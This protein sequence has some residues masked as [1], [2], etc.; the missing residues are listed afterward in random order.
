MKYISVASAVLLFASSVPT[1]AASSPSIFQKGRA[2]SGTCFAKFRGAVLMDGRCSGLGHRNS[3]LVTAKRDS[4]T[5]DITRDGEVSISAYRGECGD[6]DLGSDEEPIGKLKRVG[7]C[8][9]GP[10]AK[11]CLKAGNVVV[12]NAY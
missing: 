4:C 5:L 9:A 10:N 2:I 8:L 12:K 6:S 7:N 11:V 3:L 1:V